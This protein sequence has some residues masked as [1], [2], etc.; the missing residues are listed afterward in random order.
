MVLPDSC[1]E[2]SSVETDFRERTR[3]TPPDPLLSPF[4]AFRGVPLPIE[5]LPSVCRF[6]Q[7]RPV[8]SQW[9]PPPVR[10][11]ARFAWGYPVEMPLYA[12]PAVQRYCELPPIKR[13]NKE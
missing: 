3:S 9:T 12:L 1:A 2:T 13:K 10:P 5:V 8:E 11:A 4:I 7:N 6:T